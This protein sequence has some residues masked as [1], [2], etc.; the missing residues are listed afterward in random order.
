MSDK[1]VNTSSRFGRNRGFGPA[2]PKPKQKKKRKSRAMSKEDKARRAKERRAKRGETKA[3]L[4]RRARPIAKAT[5]KAHMGLESK[6]KSAL[7][8]YIN[9]RGGQKQSS[10]YK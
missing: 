5:K 3:E 6:D 8:K 10:Y 1:F 7:K 2:P 4:L 9:T